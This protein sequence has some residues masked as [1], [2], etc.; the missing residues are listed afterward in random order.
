MSPAQAELLN[1]Y[2]RLIADMQRDLDGFQEC[3][4]SMHCNGEDIT[5]QQMATMQE[6]IDNLRALVE[7]HDPEGVTTIV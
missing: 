4:M 6:R 7:K 1:R 2:R 5:E 3:G